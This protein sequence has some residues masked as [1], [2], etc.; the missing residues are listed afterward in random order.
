MTYRTITMLGLAL[1]ACLPADPYDAA[2]EVGPPVATRRSIAYVDEGR[3]E[4]VLVLPQDEE[5]RLVR[6]SVGDE[7]SRVLWSRST[8]DGTGVLVMTGPATD[9][10]EDVQ[11]QLHLVPADG[12]GDERTFDVLAPFTSVD[13]SPDGRRAVLHFGGGVGSGAL[14]N[15]NQVAIVDLQSGDVRNLTLNGFGGRLQSVD[16][17]VPPGQTDPVAIDVGGRP[18]ELVAFLAEGEVVL[19]DA[20]NEQVDQVAVR[21]GSEVS[22]SPVE[23][24]LRLGNESFGRPALFLRSDFGSDVAMLT[25]VD[26]ADEATGEPGFSAQVSLIPV[27][28]GATDMSSYDGQEAPYLVTA[29]G[30]A[31]VFTDIRTQQSFSVGTGGQAQRLFMRDAEAGSGTIRQ[32]VAWAPGGGALYTLDLDAIEDTIGRTPRPLIIETGIEDLVVLDNDRVLVSS[33]LNLYVV[34]LPLEQVTPLSAMSPYDARSSALDGDRLLLGTPGQTWVSTVDL[35]TLNPESMV[36]DD[37]IQSFH[38]L[39]DAGKV[40]MVHSDS[41]GHLTVADATSP[42]RSTS[43]VA[44]GYLLDG[45]LDQ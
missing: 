3:H 5:V 14:Q 37:P 10:E 38:Y 32:A 13:L 9:K 17:P 41:V 16:F 45:I 11:E 30:G 7:R 44:W 2:L 4:L 43:Y 31:M 18:L 27:G 26:K 12:D 22:F 20:G 34:D 33:G 25:L 21:F 39:Q 6:R 40:V 23:S 8:L 1:A 28:N 42:S 36:L 29:D 24:L 15:A 35:L 19:V